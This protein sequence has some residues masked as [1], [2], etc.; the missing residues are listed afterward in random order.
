MPLTFLLIGL[1]AGVLSGLFG[2][3]GGILIVPALVLLSNFPT[4]L[5]VGTS[6]GALLLPVGLLG[7]FTYWHHGNVNVRAALFVALGLTAG[8]LIGAR[9][10]HGI[11]QGMLQRLFALFMVA[12]AV[13]LW[14]EAGGK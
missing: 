13:Q 7:V 14:I 8:V 1:A 3:G 2:V 11:H 12:M 9:L 4:K 10:A 5:A 6:L